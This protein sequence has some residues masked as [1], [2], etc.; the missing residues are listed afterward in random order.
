MFHQLCYL[1]HGYITIS[2]PTFCWWIF[3]FLPSFCLLQWP[4]LHLYLV[5]S[6]CKNPDLLVSS[7]SMSRTQSKRRCE[8]MGSEEES[9]TMAVWV[10][11]QFSNRTEYF[12][13]LS[14]LPSH[15]S[16]GHSADCWPSTA[17]IWL[18]ITALLTLSSTMTA[19]EMPVLSHARPHTSCEDWHLP[20]P[21]Q[22][23]GNNTQRKKTV[24]LSS[25]SWQVEWALYYL[26]WNNSPQ[27]EMDS[28][29]W[30]HR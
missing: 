5:L 2:L 30:E 1:Y 29:P 9:Q 21:H 10:P 8:N 26:Q 20:C 12:L 11:F 17:G 7:S 14:L 16:S 13:E 6:N 18:P 15:R 28:V 22:R 3:R 4:S 27:S 23:R 24:T 19:K 25:V